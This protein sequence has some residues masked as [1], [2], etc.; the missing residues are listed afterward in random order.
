VLAREIRSVSKFLNATMVSK[1]LNATIV[2]L[3]GFLWYVA[4]TEPL[5][6]FYCCLL[7][8]NLTLLL[9]VGNVIEVRGLLLRNY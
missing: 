1:F 5:V 9:R 7:I 2:Q 8:V 6:L 4:L 3:F